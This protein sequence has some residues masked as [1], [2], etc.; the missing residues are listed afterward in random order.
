MKKYL[1]IAV[2][3]MWGSVCSQHINSADF[4]NSANPSNVI[5]EI[6]LP[7]APTVG[8]VYLNDGWH[9]GD[10]IMKGA[11]SFKGQLLRYDL[12]HQNL[13][14]KFDN[15]IKI[16][17]LSKLESFNFV[18]SDIDSSFFFVNIN[19]IPNNY[20]INTKGIAEVLYKEK[21][22]LYKYYFL[23]HREPTYV[24]TVA[25]GSK[26]AKILKKNTFYLQTPEK[27]YKLSFSFKKNKTAFGKYYFQVEKNAKENGLKLKKQLNMIAIVKYYNSL[28]EN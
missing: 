17:A 27:L 20:V 15:G 25:L 28:L 16:C 13:E 14:I 11:R 6:N 21:V 7:P 18:N 26:S 24:P 5:R 22:T 10:F 4:G 23:E 3:T 19:T 8:N 1:V 9:R 12:K 2:C